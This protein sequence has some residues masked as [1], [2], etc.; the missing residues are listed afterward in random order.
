MAMATVPR[1]HV[2]TGQ[3]PGHW[4]LSGYIFARGFDGIA[5]E[6]VQHEA[7]VCLSTF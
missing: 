7:V 6:E 3:S 5:F 2:F 1:C 4:G